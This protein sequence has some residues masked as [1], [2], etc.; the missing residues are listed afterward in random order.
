MFPLFRFYIFSNP[1]ST[2]LRFTCLRTTMNS[3]EYILEQLSCYV[4]RNCE[5]NIRVLFLRICLNNLGTR[6]AMHIYRKTVA[7]S[8]YHSYYINTAI[9]SQCNV[10]LHMSP[11]TIQIQIFMQSARYFLSDFKGIWIYLTDFEKFHENPC[12]ESRTDGRTE[13]TQV[14]GTFRDYFERA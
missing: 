1:F 4:F 9:C 12:S 8:H 10:E 3:A 6:E 7:R 11:S 5:S 13:M 2:S 14:I